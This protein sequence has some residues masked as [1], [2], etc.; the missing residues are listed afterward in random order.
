[1]EHTEAEEVRHVV[2]EAGWG[3]VEV[4]E[5][6]HLDLRSSSPE[7]IVTRREGNTLIYSGPG[8]VT[9]SVPRTVHVTVHKRT[10]PV[11]VRRVAGLTAL[12]VDGDLIAN[13]ITSAIS[14]SGGQGATILS[15]IR[16]EM[17]IEDRRGDVRVSDFSGS[18][19]IQ[20]IQGRLRAADIQGKCTVEAVR[21]AVDFRDID[22][23]LTL[24]GVDGSVRIRDLHGDMAA[25][26][27]HGDVTLEGINGPLNVRD[28][29]GS[30]YIRDVHGDLAVEAPIAGGIH[31][32]DLHGRIAISGDVEGN[33]SLA[34]LQ[35]D[36]KIKGTIGGN[37]A[38]RDVDGSVDLAGVEGHLQLQQVTSA[39]TLHGAVEGSLTARS[40]ADLVFQDV[41]GDVR[42]QDGRGRLHCQHISGGLRVRDWMGMVDTQEVGGEAELRRV[43]GEINLP[44]IEGDLRLVDCPQHVDAYCKGSLYY[45]GAPGNEVQVSLRSDGNALLALNPDVSAQLELEAGGAVQALIQLVD[46][47]G[48]GHHLAGRLGAG[49]SRVRLEAQGNIMVTQREVAAEE[50]AED[51]SGSQAPWRGRFPFGG[52]WWEGLFQGGT[53]RDYERWVER[54]SRRAAREA[55]R[56]A[57]MAER[58]ARDAEREASR[59]VSKATEEAQRYVTEA[60]HRARVAGD[61]S[62]TGGEI[63][64]TVSDA[65][66]QTLSE[67]HDSLRPEIEGLIGEVI[68]SVLRN[69]PPV[70]PP[71]PER[72]RAPRPIHVDIDEGDAGTEASAAQDSV[73]GHPA[74]APEAVRLR[75][76]QELRDGHMSIEEAERRLRQIP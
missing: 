52:D 57:R 28:V 16:A 4:V 5:G 23:Q 74:E 17:S 11:R 24:T 51:K 14:I 68:S 36:V 53:R 1:M 63:S 64:R 72:P 41:S 76:L 67:L 27:V 21:D 56:A 54:V 32:E 2:I 65:V 50:E 7:P 62:R 38:L 22:G 58:Q 40:M 71:H 9:L 60:A 37:A 3:P 44:Q 8:A 69:R 26:R 70:T 43:E 19:M 73:Q 20:R 18:M 6:A 61:V 34:D 75:I 10:A 33:L 45:A 42:V 30:L 12:E 31:G 55:K 13:E 35:G 59:W 15:D 29:A 47:E 25:A 66:R 39:V 46:Q 48:D 49:A